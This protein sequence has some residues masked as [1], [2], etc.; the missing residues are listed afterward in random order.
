[1]LA[2]QCP[3]RS[4]LMTFYAGNL[5]DDQSDELVQHLS[6]C[7]SCQ[8]EVETFNDADDS[9]IHN[10]RQTDAHDSVSDE[11]A[12][13][14]GIFRALGTLAFSAETTNQWNSEP[15]SL[16][17]RIGEYE[18]VKSI[19]RGGMGNIYLAK[20]EKL[21][22]LVAIKI[23]A[24][25]RLYD[26]R[27]KRRFESEMR[28][29]GGLSHPN[30]V[31]AH[32]ARDIDGT[33][34]LVTEY[35][36]GYDLSDLVRRTGPL[37]IENACEIMRQVANALQY[38]CN[39]GIV[40]RDI[41][42]SN[43]MLS[44]T[45]EVKLLDLGLARLDWAE[46]VQEITGTGQTMG[47]ADYISPE[48]VT[49]PRTVDVRSDIY[50]LGATL[51]KL[52]TGRA[53]FEEQ[54]TVFAKLT[55][56]VSGDVPSV[57]SLRPDVP[58]GLE[59]IIETMLRKRPEGRQQH[60]ESI[61]EQLAKYAS[62]ATLETLVLSAIS[63]QEKASQVTPSSA[64]HLPK[65]SSFWKRPIS[66]YKAIAGWGFGGAIGLCLGIWITITNPDGTKTQIALSEGSKVEITESNPTAK[67]NTTSSATVDTPQ[68]PTSSSTSPLR[69]A[70]L[71]NRDGASQG[72]TISDKELDSLIYHLHANVNAN[73]NDPSV[74]VG[75][76][77]AQ[78][79]RVADGEVGD[80]PISAWPKGYRY[81][82][83]STEPQYT[84]GWK[85]IE[86]SILSSDTNPGDLSL[87][88]KF[89]QSLAN[90][91]NSLSKS[92]V[93][94]QLGI[95]A[96]NTLVQAPRLQSEIKDEVVITGAFSQIQ[97]K[98][99]RSYLER[100]HSQ[101][102]KVIHS[103]VQENTR[104]ALTEE[105]RMKAM[106]ADIVRVFQSGKARF[107]KINDV[108]DFAKAI[109]R[110]SEWCTREPFRFGLALRAIQP[111]KSI[112]FIR[113]GLPVD[114]EWLSQRALD[115]YTI[116]ISKS[117]LLADVIAFTDAIEGEGTAAQILEGIKMDP[118]GP[119]TDFEREIINQLGSHIVF[120]ATT[121]M[122]AFEVADRDV[123]RFAIEKFNANEVN[124]LVRVRLVDDYIVC[125]PEAVLKEIAARA[126]KRP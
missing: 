126:P 19:G 86:G 26:P 4:R 60:P 79:V 90:R 18:I 100:S 71:V 25:H 72:P 61:A 28:A 125:G 117:N 35:I 2:T 80:F 107:N 95:I 54:S 70:L 63:N 22:R 110:T 57:R 74:S 97:W 5:P 118:Q 50:S 52:L 120:D 98:S 42:P 12:C 11:P 64:N 39:L 43:I 67:D 17:S 14:L 29:L 104:L 7:T 102:R 27:A 6:E 37:S 111:M 124:P 38:T 24:N 85:D 10:L 89:D 88:L 62:N 55:A 108:E 81:V 45:G 91:M 36:E 92:C 9:L 93:G 87:K 73:P 53:P 75:N 41:K 94:L 101:N 13:E 122:W 15:E 44:R 34:V 84:V 77:A 112:R 82:L 40:H 58:I 51:Y 31:T 30:I 68:Y 33:A 105:D 21:Q 47:T 106:I 116:E 1:M 56:H 20:H 114:K 121:E 103:S 66:M 119:K 23:L 65:T 16:P 76:Q 32:D 78:F 49:D 46:S 83:V 69:F 8:C 48:Q 3:D 115:V 109:V 99:M 113:S 59:R 123:T 96:D